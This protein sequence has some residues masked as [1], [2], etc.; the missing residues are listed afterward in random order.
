MQVDICAAISIDGFI[1][2]P[3][4]DSDWTCD[5][6]LFEKI[7]Q[8]YGCVALG[9]TTFTQYENELYPM[10][11]IEHIVLTSNA[12]QASHSPYVHFAESV[13]KAL[14]VAQEL[15]F[16]KLL[17]IGGAKTNESFVKAGAVDNILLDI[18]PLTLGEG[19]KLFGD[20]KQPLE[21]QL[22]SSKADPAGF[23]HVEYKLV[24]N[25]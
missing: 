7:C 4:G 10:D 17:V 14:A 5:D 3:D 12:N 11:D 6:V 18:H 24:E 22:A 25:H 1:A 8:D 2:T 21:L 20:H 9:H 13:E 15:G 23:V 19:I 16:S